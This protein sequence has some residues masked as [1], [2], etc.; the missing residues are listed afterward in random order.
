MKAY[1]FLP[2]L[3]LLLLCPGSEALSRSNFPRPAQLSNHSFCGAYPGRIKDEIHKARALR[4]LIEPNLS[5]MALRSRVAAAR[6]VGNVSI[7]EDDGTIVSQANPFDLAS[8][9]LRMVPSG[10]TTFSLSVQPGSLNQDLGTKL[11]LSDDDYSQI[12]FPTGFHFP[13]LGASYG[14]VFINSDGNVTF[15]QGD[16][17]HTDRDLGRFNGGPPRIA[18]LFDDLDPTL[19]DGG[20]YYNALADRFLITWNRVREF[21]GTQP[22][23][24]QLALYSDGSFELTYGSITASSL[25]VGWSAGQGL[26]TVNLIDLSKSSGTLPSGPVAEHFSTTTEI[27]FTSLAKAFYLTHPDNFEQ[28]AIYTNF[29]YAIGQDTFAFE[30][31]V[32]NDIQGINLET[33]DYSQEFGSAGRLQSFL[34]MNQL[35]AFPADPDT[36]AVRTY[37]TV[38]VMAHETAHRWLA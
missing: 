37:S 21:G 11:S 17:A 3:A 19:G 9:N 24:V 29:P 4:Q 12:T 13:F 14:S 23:T 5:R 16:D 31:G 32:K 1:R 30:A 28:L 2:L 27:D 36:I 26:Q 20:V 8:T 18:T 7:I 10:A 35:A 33:F 15:T 22:N 38:A 25:I 34:A 6:D